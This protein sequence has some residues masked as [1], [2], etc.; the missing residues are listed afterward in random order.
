[1]SCTI[2]A[3]VWSM[4][5]IFVLLEPWSS[6]PRADDWLLSVWVALEVASFEVESK[7]VPTETFVVI[8]RDGWP[9]S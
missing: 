9:L 4:I 8:V 3:A 2:C 6:P 5:T 7:R 1:M